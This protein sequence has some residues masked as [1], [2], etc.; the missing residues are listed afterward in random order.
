M[1]GDLGE[2]GAFAADDDAA[3]ESA[4][5]RL[6]DVLIQ[7]FGEA[8]VRA[9]L[10]PGQTLPESIVAMW[11]KDPFARGCY[12]VASPGTLSIREALAE[13]ERGTLFLA[14]EHVGGWDRGF[15]SATITAALLSGVNAAARLA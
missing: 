1:S 11:S 12:S 4:V 13:G 7:I 15:R 8:T 3:R 14:G 10:P 6:L 5:H 2:S 9:A